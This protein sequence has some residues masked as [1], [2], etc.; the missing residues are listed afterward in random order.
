MPYKST[1]DLPTATRSLPEHAKEVFRAAFN[2]AHQRNPKDEQS[3]FRIAWA[4]AK[5][6]RRQKKQDAEEGT[7]MQPLLKHLQGLVQSMQAATPDLDPA[8]QG[9]VA[10]LHLLLEQEVKDEAGLETLSRTLEQAMG[11]MSRPSA[12]FE[13]SLEERIQVLCSEVREQG[14]VGRFGFVVTVFPDYL[15][16]AD[17]GDDYYGCCDEDPTYWKIPYTVNDTNDQVTFGER[18]EVELQMVAVEVGDAATGGTEQSAIE[19]ANLFQETVKKKEGASEFGPGA[20]LIVPDRSEPSTWKVRVEETPGNVTAKQLGA[21]HA[22]LTKGFRGN[23][24]QASGDEKSKALKRLAGLYKKLGADMPGGADKQAAETDP[25][26][27]I[28]GQE[29]PGGPEILTQSQACILQSLG[30]DETTGIMTVSGVATTG[31]VLNKMAQVYP[32]QI[33]QDN[34]PRLQ[35]LLQ[36]GRL[37]G[38]IM[39]PS[40]GRASLDRTCLKYT[41]VWLEQETK[42]VMFEAE[43]IPTE[44]HGKNLQMLIQSGVSV[45]ISSRGAGQFATGKWEGTQAQIVQ[46]GFRCDAFDAVISGAS[47]GSTILDWQLQS[48]A[49]SED[50]EEDEMTKEMMDKMAASLERMAAVQEEQGKAI[51]TLTQAKEVDVTKVETVKDETKV[52][53]KPVVQATDEKA[54]ATQSATAAAMEV[55]LARMQRINAMQEKALVQGGIE[56]LCQE[57][58]ETNKFVGPWNNSYR[59]MLKNAKCETLEALDQANTQI[60]EML[61]S[62]I[63]D[64]PKFPALG[65]TV[66]K[67]VGDRGFKTGIELIDHLVSDLP[68]DMPDD[69]SGLFQQADPEHPSETMI[70]QSFRTPRRHVKQVLMNMARYQDDVFDG[71]RCLKA[72]VQLSQGRNYKTVAE[73]VLYQSCADGTT[74]VG[75]GGAPSSALFIFPLVRRVYPRL[76][77]TEVASVQPMDRPDGKIF[78]LDTVRKDANGY[79]DEAGADVANR[80]PIQRS[81]SFSDSYADDPG[82]CESTLFVQLKMSSKS[83]TAQTKKLSAAWT[84]EELQDLRAYHNLDVSLELVGGLSREV[85]LEWNNLVLNEMLNGAL[86][87]N[88]NFGTTAPSGYTQ[89]E[90]DE[91]LPRYIDA[92]SAKVFK[93]RNGDITHLIAGPDAWVKLSATHRIATNPNSEVPTQ[94]EGVTMTPWMGGSTP[95]LKV[96][97]TSF[98][99]ARNAD[100]ILAIRRGDDWSDTPYVWAPYID[101]V[102]PVLTLPDTFNQKQGIMSR[103]AHKVVVGQAMGTITIQQGV[104]GTPL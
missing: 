14:I 63:Q 9:A 86:A 89:K 70:P 20:Y 38:E 3:A 32:W 43:V 101:Y 50:T 23:K 97:K 46:R 19:V 67:D 94:F 27:L 11:Y 12:H 82:E 25:D 62:M 80:M 56:R 40:E 98:W 102:S 48:D 35:R 36:Q 54:T 44:P 47:P 2:S 81:D 77:A 73:E 78:Y 75:A 45:D 99:N 74:A 34:E 57:A 58:K 26:W 93:Q 72:L 41:K 69:P 68:D 21:A 53:D 66:Q 24:V 4:A 60:S 64:A 22:A 6:V 51:A 85:A 10:A 91:Y 96:F 90:W 87:G 88:L 55:E 37:V 100:K 79:T 42:Q 28:Q 15:I 84:I 16:A 17:P 76:I 39:H 65:F 95:N 33:W 7:D 59:N 18:V 92:I 31:D 61:A 5:K 83:I 104:T 13:G 29:P 52:E 30:I 49:S 71:P 1:K 103:V 8:G